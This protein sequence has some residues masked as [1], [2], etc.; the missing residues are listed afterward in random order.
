M[1]FLKYLDDLEQEKAMEA[2]LRGKTYEYIIDNA[3]RWASRSKR[4]VVRTENV[5]VMRARA[6]FLVG[7]RPLRG[8]LPRAIQR[9]ARRPGGSCRRGNPWH[10]RRC[11]A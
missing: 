3:H 10:W 4:L 5:D 8:D 2:E 9:E 11:P 7:A 1:L 6:A